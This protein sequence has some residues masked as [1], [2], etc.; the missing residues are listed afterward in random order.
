MTRIIHL[1]DWKTG[2]LSSGSGEWCTCEVRRVGDGVL[3]LRIGPDRY[4]LTNRGAV[5]LAH[6]L[7]TVLGLNEEDVR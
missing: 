2:R 7:L 1:E 5:F 6:E 4:E 3:E